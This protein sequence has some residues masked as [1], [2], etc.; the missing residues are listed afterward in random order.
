MR[1]KGFKHSEETKKRISDSK[2]GKLGH[3]WNQKQRTAVI[4]AITIHGMSKTKTY[5]TWQS[6]K[7]RCTNPSNVQYMDYGGRG[8][9]VCEEWMKFE[10]FFEDMGLRPEGMS[11][12][13]IDNEKG[14]SKENCRWATEFEQKRNTRRNHWIT[15]NG[16]TKCLEDWAKEIGIKANT[17]INRLN[18]SKWPLEKALTTP[19]LY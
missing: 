15:F 17:L 13:R 8:I 5:R 16:E 6:M 4:E 14:Y 2:T 1:Q 19:A 18:R 12:D 11:L 10:N 7:A 3:G 9:G